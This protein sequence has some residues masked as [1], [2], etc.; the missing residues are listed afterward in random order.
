MDKLFIYHVTYT[1]NDDITYSQI[2]PI[3]AAGAKWARMSL[4]QHFKDCG[5]KKVKLVRL[6]LTD[7]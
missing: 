5:Y 6:A 1:N 7:F 3:W 2:C 4:S